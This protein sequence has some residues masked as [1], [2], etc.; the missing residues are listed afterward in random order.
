MIRYIRLHWA[1]LFRTLPFVA[2]WASVETSAQLI[3][4]PYAFPTLAGRSQSGD[5]DGRGIAAGFDHPSSIASDNS[6]NLYVADTLNNTIRKIT[7]EGVVTTIAGVAGNPG[8]VDG[9]G[10]QA[11]FDTPYGLISD[12]AGNIFVADTDNATI[13]KLTLIGTNWFVTTIA[14]KPGE[15]GGVDGVGAEA[16]FRFPQDVTIDGAGNLYVADSDDSTIRKITR[17]GT[18]WVVTTIAGKT[19]IEGS[20]DGLGSEARFTAPSGLAADSVG[21]I[22]VAD[23]F[24]HTIRMVTPEGVVTTLAGKPGEEGSADGFGSVARFNGPFGVATDQGGNVYIADSNNSTI[25]K[26]TR[27]GVDWFVTTL[28]GR[29]GNS[30][31]ANGIGGA[32]RFDYPTGI[33]TDSEGHIYIADAGNN[34]ILKGIVASSNLISN[35]AGF[36]FNGGR[37][38]FVIEGPPQQTVVVESSSDLYH[39]LPLSTNLLSDPIHFSDSGPTSAE[40]RFF[41]AYLTSPVPQ[42]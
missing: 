9:M 33:A 1:A 30:G 16:R 6:G 37:F 36:G 13:R 8:S 26:L 19:E 39:W 21:N 12:S 35:G 23:R 18:N 42:P 32:A 20:T 4:T 28:G 31:S 22:Y 5:L 11:R 27:V 17:A 10:R 3:E 41:R 14:G 7:S 29:A 2:L 38:G 15:E 40:N 24:D 34:M 25:R